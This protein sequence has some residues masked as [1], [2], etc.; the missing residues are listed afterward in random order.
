MSKIVVIAPSK[1][2]AD[3][4]RTVVG[5]HHLKIYAPQ[6]DRDF[7]FEETVPIAQQEEARGAEV[8]IT[9]GG[10]AT[11][12]KQKVSIPVVEV[13]MTILDI[14]RTVHHLKRKYQRIGLIGVENIICDYR[15]LGRYIDIQI[16]PVFSYEDD[17]DLR[18]RQAIS[19]GMECIV[20]DGMSVDYAKRFGLPGIKLM[21]SSASVQEAIDLA[22]N[23][24][25]ARFLESTKNEQFRMVLETAQDA[26]L[27]ISNESQVLLA[28]HRATHL[29][30]QDRDD[31]LNYP[32]SEV[33]QNEPNLLKLIYQSEEFREEI[34]QVRN[35]I[36]SVSK[37]RITVAGDPIGWVLTMQDVTQIQ[38]LEQTIRRKLSHTGF[39]AKRSLQDIAAV[40]PN[41]KIV[42]EK[43]RHFSKADSTTLLLGETGTG[44]EL[45]A[46]SIHNHSNRKNRPFVP[47]NCAALPGNLLE[48]ELFGYEPGAFTGANRNGKAGLFE[49]AHTGTIFL[50]EIGEMP[51]DLQ[52]RLLRVIQER[53]VMRIG[54]SAIIPVDV[55]II[56]ATHRDLQSD[57]QSGKFR[58]DL[59]YRLNILTIHIPPLRA[60]KED[61]PLLVD[62]L[63]TN[64]CKRY[65]RPKP[66][67]A[68][69]FID[70]LTRF[71]WPG[72]I[73]QLEN[74]LERIV[75]L[76]NADI[77]QEQ[78]LQEIVEELS[79]SDD[80]TSPPR[81]REPNLFP[82]LD[83][84][85][86]D[87]ERHVILRRLEAFEGNKDLTAKHLGISR[88]TLWR[89]LKELATEG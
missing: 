79:A 27:I 67:L 20:G 23:I 81:E 49:L 86:E 5:E 7:P 46:Q 14:L 65:E 78:V 10:Q 77:P 85:L 48:S 18:V 35:F 13:K 62:A 1:E 31:I 88:A 32:I 34:V 75:V 4:V 33:L 28:N 47:I 39:V 25:R 22:E 11:L 68:K 12:L 43:I 73:R 30:C 63:L 53:E 21:P 52:S 69:S 82:I 2:F 84:T 50:D 19:D 66:Q 26:I 51:L 56:A 45:I 41:M 8:I 38:K 64:I 71:T 6:D 42:I 17:L 83:G 72:N 58:A 57:I 3:T 54:G 76:F 89:K 80:A 9:R 36:L 37:R 87:I 70:Q 74:V 29:L 16:Y 40:S 44:K 24:I 60:R 59:F 15:E 61:I 55:R